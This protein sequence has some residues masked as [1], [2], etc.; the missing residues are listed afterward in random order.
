MDFKSAENMDFNLAL[1]WMKEEYK[2]TG[3]EAKFYLH[4]AIVFMLRYKKLLEAQQQIVRC[5][6]C[7]YQ[8]FKFKDGRIVCG[9]TDNGETHPSDWFCAD[10]ER[11]DDG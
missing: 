7:Q 2:Q 3:G 5:K 4:D 10:G 9:R 8:Y 11:K 6:D 1:N